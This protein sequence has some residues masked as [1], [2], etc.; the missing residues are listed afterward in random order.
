MPSVNTLVV[1]DGVLRGST[2]DAAILAGLPQ[3]RPVI[4][5]DGGAAAA[6]RQ[7]LPHARVY[8]RRG[9]WPPDVRGADLVVH[10]TTVRDEVLFEVEPEQT[11]VDLPYPE[12][13]TARARARGRRDGSPTGS[14]SSS[15][16]A[17]PRS[18]SGP[19]SPRRVTS[20]APQY[21]P[22]RDARARDRRG[23]AR[24]C[25]RRDRQRAA[26]R[27][28]ARPRR[29]RRRPAPPPAGLRPQ[30]APAARAGRGRG[31][32]RAAARPHARDAARARRPQPRPQE[33]D[34][35]DEP[36]AAGGRAAAGRG[37]SR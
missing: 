24:P 4:V 5:G 28:D 34:V 13:A 29:D 8:S 12:T 32:R 3:E 6:F 19:G 26:R 22:P 37:R 35:G 15:R 9:E 17:R 14:T 10:A 31:A 18:S 2:T 33:L 30:P 20:C 25:A 16:R 36:V 21:A 11:L 23:I 27:A 1:R 7:A